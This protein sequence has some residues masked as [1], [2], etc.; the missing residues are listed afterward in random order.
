MAPAEKF[1]DGTGREISGPHRMEM[2]IPTVI[3]TQF[4]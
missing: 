4:H 3:E 1:Q 2:W